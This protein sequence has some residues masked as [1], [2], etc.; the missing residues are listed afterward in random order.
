MRNARGSRKHECGYYYEDDTTHPELPK[1]HGQL[2][3][4]ALTGSRSMSLTRKTI[5]E[6]LFSGTSPLNLNR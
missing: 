5:G 6:I 4:K 3:V 2:S 1:Q